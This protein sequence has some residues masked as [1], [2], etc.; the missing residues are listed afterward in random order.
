MSRLAPGRSR[1][2]AASLSLA[3]LTAALLVAPA[4]RASNVAVTDLPEGPGAA[5]EPLRVLA[6]FV[7]EAPSG[8]TFRVTQPSGVVCFANLE[9]EQAE[10]GNR[11][12]SDSDNSFRSASVYFSATNPTNAANY[13]IEHLVL[14]PA[15]AS[16]ERA[17]LR[18]DAKA[19]TFSVVGTARFPMTEIYRSPRGLVLYGYRT[20]TSIH[21]VVPSQPNATVRILAEPGHA[22]DFPFQNDCGLTDLRIPLAGNGPF[23]QLEGKLN[24]P[25]DGEPLPPKDSAARKTKPKPIKFTLGISVTKTARDPAPILSFAV[26]HPD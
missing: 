7:Q 6:S 15:G 12:L 20:T 4:G 9:D 11:W 17:L 22:S 14:T 23:A 16:L 3:T 18:I 24:P 26:Q 1:I 19:A 5:A 10:K 13:G 2:R 21:V 8:Q 25:K